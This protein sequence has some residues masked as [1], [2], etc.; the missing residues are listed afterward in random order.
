MKLTKILM[1]GILSVT[2][3][4]ANETL[5]NSMNIMQ[6]GIEEVQFGFINHNEEMIR[7]GIE[8][9]N[10]GNTMFSDEALIKQ[11]L[12]SDKK[13]MVNVASNAAKRITEDAKNMEA[14][15]NEKA[16]VK[17]TEVYS[18]M[19]NACSTCHSIVRSW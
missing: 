8:A 9:I 1:A 4:S 13:H 18:D 16:Y 5:N 17:A 19:L 2:I 12:P 14:Y 3:A 10:K 7:K 15:L 11:S 6:Q